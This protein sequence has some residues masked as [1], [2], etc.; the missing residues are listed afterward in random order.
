LETRKGETVNGQVVREY[1]GRSFIELDDTLL[2]VPVT[3]TP[4]LSLGSAVQVVINHVDARRDILS[5]R[6][7]DAVQ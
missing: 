6:L 3:T 2:V 5:V 4:P 7:A 1:N